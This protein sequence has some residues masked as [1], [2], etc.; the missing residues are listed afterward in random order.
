MLFASIYKLSKQIPFPTKQIWIKETIEYFA[1]ATVGKVAL[2]E[3]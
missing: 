1:R 2:H 3:Y